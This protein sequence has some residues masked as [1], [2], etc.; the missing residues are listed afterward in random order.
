MKVTRVLS[1]YTKALR[2]LSREMKLFFLYALGSIIGIGSYALLYNLYLVQLSWH[3][4][5]N[6]IANAVSTGSLALSAFALSRI[7]E[8]LA[9]GG[10]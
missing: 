8:R 4:D 10:A 2:A 6:G 7:L 5:F 1:G 9:P 3:E